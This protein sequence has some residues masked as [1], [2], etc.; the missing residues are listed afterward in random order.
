[1][2]EWYLGSSLV[3][4]SFMQFSAPNLCLFTSQCPRGLTR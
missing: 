1:M 3:Y 2:N 4:A